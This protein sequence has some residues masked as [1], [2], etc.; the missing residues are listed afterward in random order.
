MRQQITKI[1]GLTVNVEIVEMSQA[2]KNGG[3]L[4]Y[5]AAVYVQAHGSAEKKLV[6]KSRLPGTAAELRKALQKDGLQFFRSLAT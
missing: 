2:D 4:C 1:K 3:I 6:R 5:V